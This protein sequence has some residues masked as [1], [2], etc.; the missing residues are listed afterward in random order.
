MKLAEKIKEYLESEDM[1]YKPYELFSLFAED[2]PGQYD[3]FYK[4]LDTLEK[5]GDIVYTKKGKISPIF[6]Q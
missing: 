6:P 1:S 3:A 4:A 2:D 5:S